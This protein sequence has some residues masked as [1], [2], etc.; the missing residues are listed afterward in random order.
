DHPPPDHPAAHRLS[1]HP[2]R[3]LAHGGLQQIPQVPVHPVHWISRSI[4]P[5]SRGSSRNLATARASVALTVPTAQSSTCA[6]CAS[7]TT[8]TPR[9]RAVLDPNPPPP[10]PRPAPPAAPPP[11][12]RTSGT[13]PVARSPHH[14]RRRQLAQ[15]L[16][17]AR[18]T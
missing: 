5:A 6:T 15:L 3:R 4:N 13:A 8:T 7:G 11:T 17:I 10:G 18:R 16:T 14:R 1:A 12:P 9:C 2:V